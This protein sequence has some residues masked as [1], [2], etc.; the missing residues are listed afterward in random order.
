MLK[1]CI[2]MFHTLTI[3]KGK[4]AEDE[5]L[6]SRTNLLVETVIVK[7]ICEELLFP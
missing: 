1:V 7:I 6:M 3:I 4:L 2:P 5:N